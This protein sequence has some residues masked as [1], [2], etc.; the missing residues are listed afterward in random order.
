MEP[1]TNQDL[2]TDLHVGNI[3]DYLNSGGNFLAQCHA[4]QAYETETPPVESYSGEL[5]TTLGGLSNQTIPN[6]D[7]W[8]ASSEALPFPFC[9]Y[10]Q[11][12]DYTLVGSNG[13]I[14]FDI[15]YEINCPIK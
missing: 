15:N 12:Y 8:A 4:V 3:V 1:H 6:D 2:V 11:E 9:F 5:L 7:V 13:F 14:T 10:D